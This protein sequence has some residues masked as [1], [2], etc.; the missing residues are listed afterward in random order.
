MQNARAVL[1]FLT[2]QPRIID[3]KGTG[4]ISAVPM[5]VIGYQDGDA[6]TRLKDARG[7]S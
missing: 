7:I 1:Y 3:E 2:S 4:N 5:V 6:R